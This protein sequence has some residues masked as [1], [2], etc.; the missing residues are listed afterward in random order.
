ML[1]AKDPG[2]YNWLDNGGLKDGMI[3]TRWELFAHPLPPGDV[4]QLVRE[5]RVVKLSERAAALP[6][7]MAKVT[8]AQRKQQMKTRAA[9]YAKRVA[10]K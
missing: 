9:E 1:S 8:P 3:I 10:L 4:P 5:A 2:V 7:D 6:A